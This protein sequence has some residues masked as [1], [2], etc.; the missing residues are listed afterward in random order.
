[1]AVMR[2]QSKRLI[3]GIILLLLAYLIFGGIRW[4]W[5]RYFYRVSSLMAYNLHKMSLIPCGFLKYPTIQLFATTSATIFWETNCPFEKVRFTLQRKVAYRSGPKQQLHSMEGEEEHFNMDRI[6]MIAIS[7]NRVLYRIELRDLIG[8]NEYRYQIRLIPEEQSLQRKGLARTTAELTP[9]RNTFYFP[10]GMASQ[11]KFCSI[12]AS[13]NGG[14]TFARL[15][16]S[17]AG[18]RPELLI[19][20]GK[21]VSQPARRYNWQEQFFDPLHQSGLNSKTLL[22][23]LVSPEERTPSSSSAMYY[24]PPLNNKNSYY[25]AISVGPLRIII[26][27]CTTY[28]D[29]QN[30]WIESE[31]ASVATQRIPFRILFLHCPLYQEFSSVAIPLHDGL[32]QRQQLLR[33]KLLPLLEKY[34][35]DLV[36]AGAQQNYQ[37]GFHNGIHFVNSGGGGGELH[38]VRIADYHLFKVTHFKHHY[39]YLSADKN[40]LILKVMDD[41]DKLID[42]LVIPRNVIRRMRIGE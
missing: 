37:R 8:D 16:N 25:H 21:M 6:K 29:E 11:V 2:R 33:T 39:L 41:R 30:K 31:L 4:L 15:L 20:L 32:Q 12:G 13:Q 18:K 26:V 7:K 40:D 14:L 34:H 27:D 19:H 3:R 24:F 5:R 1:M 9:Y 17:I 38:R 36:I 22:I 28:D 23:P 10:G 42:E 35:V